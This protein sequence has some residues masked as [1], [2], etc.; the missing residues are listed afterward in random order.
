MDSMMMQLLINI[1]NDLYFLTEKDINP[2]V[3]RSNYFQFSDA[4]RENTEDEKPR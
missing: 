3:I 4:I 1:Y 2:A